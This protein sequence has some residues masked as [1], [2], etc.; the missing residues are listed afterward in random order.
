MGSGQKR[1]IS[2][3]DDPRLLWLEREFTAYTEAIQESSKAR[4]KDGF[5]SETFEALNFTTKSTVETARFLLRNGVDSR[6]LNSDPIE[7]IF[8]RI[9][10]M[11]GGNDMLDARA[12]TTAL[13]HIIKSEASIGKKL[14]IPCV[15]AEELAA[16]LP[17]SLIEELNHLAKYPVNPSPSVR[18]SGLA[19]VAGYIVKLISDFGC[20]ACSILLETHERSDPLYTLL[21]SQDSSGLHYPKEEFVALLDK[22]V[23]FFEKA[24][25]HLPR[26]NVLEV[27][28]ILIQP[29]LENSP[30]LCC[31]EG[32]D[33][34]HA[35]RCAG[36][37]SEKFVRILLI[38]YAQKVT[39][40]NV[41]RPTIYVHKPS[42]KHF[43]L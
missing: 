29:H 39:D 17:Q 31:P 21:Q 6:K 27:L 22:V 38:N 8:G 11:C 33:N 30:L 2:K 18:Y 40:K 12:V 20:D 43:R 23:C 16:A 34:S 24:V 35:I 25:V 5:T 26:T 42:R 14:T 7:A 9:R 13:D 28:R 3:T 41:L 36:L 37:I 10:F 15:D 4:G 32:V 1:P 19:Y